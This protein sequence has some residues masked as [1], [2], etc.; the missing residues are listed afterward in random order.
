MYIFLLEA[1]YEPKIYLYSFLFSYLSCV[2]LIR[3]AFAHHLFALEG[4][5]QPL[6]SSLFVYCQPE[7]NTFNTYSWLVQYSFPFLEIIC[8]FSYFLNFINFRSLPWP[9]I[10]KLTCELTFM[11]SIPPLTFVPIQP[12]HPHNGDILVI[13]VGQN[14]TKAHYYRHCV[15]A[16]HG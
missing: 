13:L 5:Q 6:S 9:P 14:Y 2:F 8:M 1:G 12:P 16:V 3:H 4:K 11:P 15:D 10:W 7:P